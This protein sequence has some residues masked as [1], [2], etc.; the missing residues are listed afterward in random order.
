MSKSTRKKA[1]TKAAAVA[2]PAA[3]VKAQAAPKTAPRSRRVFPIGQCHH[4][5]A[6]GNPDCT[7]KITLKRANLCN[8]HEKIWQAAAR[9]RYAAK[10]GTTV[11][12]PAAEAT[13]PEQLEETLAASVSAFATP[14]LA[15]KARAKRNGQKV[16]AAS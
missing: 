15:A 3:K 4:R 6:Q 16:A 14:E 5:D 11:A 12:A 2:T 1:A 9:L 7:Q 8:P 10:R 13:E